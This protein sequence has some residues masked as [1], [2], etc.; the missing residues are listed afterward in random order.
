V[1]IS[2]ARAFSA[3]VALALFSGIA[4]AQSADPAISGKEL[5]IATKQAPP[6]VIKQSDG[7]WHG[8]SVDL[9]RR[10]A[11]RLHLRYRFSEQ[12]TVEALVAGTA[13]GSFDAAIAAL[14][15][16]ATRDRIVDFSQP[17]YSTGLGIAV[18][19]EESR[20][21]SVSR[22][23]LSFGFLQAVLALVGIAILVGFVIWLLER[24]KTE[25][26]GG[27]TRGLGTGLW[28]SATAMTQAGAAQNAPA[29]LPGR[30]VAIG[31]MIASVIV[32]A[33][34]TAGITSTL[35]KR[36]LRG[37]VTGVS[38]LRSV[39]VGAPAD[40]S[41]A[42]YLDHQRISHRGFS[43]PQ[44][45]LKALQAG[46]IDAFVYDKPLLAWLILRDFSSTLRVL[47]VTFDNQ[48]YAIAL[49]KGS[50][51][52]E[53]INAPLLEETESEWW[54]QTLFDYLGKTEPHYGSPG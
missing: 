25:H 22:A 26:F 47:D 2:R 17:F 41:S 34:F 8:I 11:D 37:A 51:L 29:T 54:Q 33:V 40:T 10:I 24:R 9:W 18:S 52:R 13:D 45:G 28:W 6:F 4:Q 21:M 53:M 44:E 35:T 42:Y 48:N 32:I 1:Q 7:T 12:P 5:V 23:L 38:D 39:R 49:P 46:T 36:E 43:G 15:V 19:I 50:P 16:T 27:G 31:W 30:V 3:L 14:T 20:W